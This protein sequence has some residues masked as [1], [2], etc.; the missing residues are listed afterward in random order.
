MVRVLLGRVVLGKTSFRG[1][2]YRSFR[3]FNYE[4]FL[5]DMHGI[6]F[7]SVQPAEGNVNAAC[8][9]FDSQVSNVIDKHNPVKQASRWMSWMGSGT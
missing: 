3:G 7:S 2:N 1:F 8:E 4:K 6:C 5:T 9:A